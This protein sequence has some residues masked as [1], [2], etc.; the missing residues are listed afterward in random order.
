MLFIGT[1]ILVPIELDTRALKTNI[2]NLGTVIF[3]V[4]NDKLLHLSGMMVGCGR[5]GGN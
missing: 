1:F 4:L 2:F 5:G 3:L